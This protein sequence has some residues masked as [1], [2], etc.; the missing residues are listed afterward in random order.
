MVSGWHGL[1][2]CPTVIT[3]PHLTHPHVYHTMTS[4]LLHPQRPRQALTIHLTSIDCKDSTASSSIVWYCSELYCMCLLGSIGP[5]IHFPSTL[6]EFTLSH[7]YTSLLNIAVSLDHSVT[8]PCSLWAPLH[9]VFLY[10]S[11]LWSWHDIDSHLI[12]SCLLYSLWL[13]INT[14]LQCCNTPVLN[15]LCLELNFTRRSHLYRITST[16][17][18][19]CSTYHLSPSSPLLSGPS[20]LPL[21]LP[22]SLTPW[23]MVYHLLRAGS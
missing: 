9:V 15:T 2:S 18:L 13:T 16:L 6:L 7:R 4:S 19:S 3:S 14:C 21:K 5:M 1:F 22:Q 17:L 10:L 23:P 8:E 20:S 12:S 11:M